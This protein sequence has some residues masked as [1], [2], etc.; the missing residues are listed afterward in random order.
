MFNHCAVEVYI[1]GK[2][3]IKIRFL[4]NG[5]SEFVFAAFVESR[6]RI[7]TL[8][9]SARNYIGVVRPFER[10]ADRNRYRFN[11]LFVNV[12]IYVVARGCGFF[13]RFDIFYRK[14]GVGVITRNVQTETVEHGNV[15]QRRR[16]T[17]VRI[18]FRTGEIVYDVRPAVFVHGYIRAVIFRADALRDLVE[19]ELIG[20]RH[21]VAVR[22]IPINIRARAAFE[23]I[24]EFEKFVPVRRKI[25][26]FRVYKTFRRGVSYFYALS[27]AGKRRRR[28]VFTVRH[29]QIS[30]REI[31]IIGQF[32]V[33]IGSRVDR[34][35]EI[36]F[37]RK[38]G[39]RVIAENFVTLELFVALRSL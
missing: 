16:N 6:S 11:A 37:R 1:V 30:R 17:A 31:N 10:F 27:V 7:I 38:I 35:F 28:A 20:N 15:F 23:F 12:D 33:N 36:E 39:R 32:N 13:M 8:Y 24:R 18:T 2:F 5:R 19:I 29:R 14:R 3:R 21:T 22:R 9:S 25:Q 26:I 4:F 34:G